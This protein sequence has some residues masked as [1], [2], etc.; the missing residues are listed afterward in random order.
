[1]FYFGVGGV[2]G[3]LYVF[4]IIPILLKMKIRALTKAPIISKIKMIFL[5][6]LNS[7]PIHSL[8]LIIAV[9]L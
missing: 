8:T 2:G 3:D 5:I 9:A 1:M 7:F 6:P 4:L